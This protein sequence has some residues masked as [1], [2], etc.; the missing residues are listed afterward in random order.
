MMLEEEKRSV[1]RQ[2]RKEERGVII[3]GEKYHKAGSNIICI[4]TV[5][6]L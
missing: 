2:K 6:T 3:V 4:Q 5:T 1:R